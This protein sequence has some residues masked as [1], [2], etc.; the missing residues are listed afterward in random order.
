M[1]EEHHNQIW[2]ILIIAVVLFTFYNIFVLSNT[3]DKILAD[4]N[5]ATEEKTLSKWCVEGKPY[6]AQ[7]P[8]TNLT[9]TF[10]I[11]S[12]EDLGGVPT[13]L[14][15]LEKSKDEFVFLWLDQD[16]DIVW[17]AHTINETTIEEGVP[18]AEDPEAKKVQG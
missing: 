14:L 11:S 7:N 10:T 8:T 17:Y 16:E 3:Y 9:D 6:D 1:N 12:T 15:S 13:C 18:G 5:Q 4:E 2:I